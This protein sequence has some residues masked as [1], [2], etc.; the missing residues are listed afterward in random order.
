MSVTI[1]SIEAKGKPATGVSVIWD[2][3]QFV[4]IVA[5]KG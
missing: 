4:F 1:T 5:P 2:D 3:G